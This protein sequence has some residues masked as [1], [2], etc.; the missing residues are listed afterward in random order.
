MKYVFLLSALC[1]QTL[2]C[3]AA[4]INPFVAGILVT[5]C[6]GGAAVNIANDPGSPGV[7]TLNNVACGSSIIRAKVTAVDNGNPSDL[8]FVGA[9][10]KNVAPGNAVND[11]YMISLGGFALPNPGP[12]EGWHELHGSVGG[13]GNG[14]ASLDVVGTLNGVGTPMAMTGVLANN[15]L[16]NNSSFNNRTKNIDAGPPWT[17]TATYHWTF[18]APTPLT[19][20]IHLEQGQGNNFFE[21]VPEPSTLMLFSV[22]AVLLGGSGFYRRRWSGSSR[23]T[24]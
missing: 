10:I 17:R 12:A 5:S 4:T 21:A 15:A 8:L 13:L 18:D 14:M 19:G 3:S 20:T 1:I 16:F 22:G 24:I 11:T 6:N 9:F 23:S 7:W 2:L